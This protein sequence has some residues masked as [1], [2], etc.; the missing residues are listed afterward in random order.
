MIDSLQ[1]WWIALSFDLLATFLF[2]FLGLKAKQ[3]QRSAFMLG[4]LL[5][6]LDSVI[7]IAVQ[8]Y[9]GL[10]FH[11]FVLLGFLGGLQAIHQIKHVGHTTS[12]YPG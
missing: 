1:I 12:A 3:A 4:I 2:I 7:F 9:V 8:D 6:G 11:A 5:Y 10:I